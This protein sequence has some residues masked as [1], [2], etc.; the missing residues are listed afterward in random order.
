GNGH[1]LWGEYETAYGQVIQAVVR[2]EPPLFRSSCKSRRKPSKYSLA[3]VL[4]FL[5]RPEAW[6]VQEELPDWALKLLGQQEEKKIPPSTKTN[7]AAQQKR[8]RLMDEGVQELDKW[9]GNLARQGLASAATNPDDWERIAQRMVDC[10]L[11]G[12]GG[13]I[14]RAHEQFTT[15]GWLDDVAGEVGLLYL[16]VRAWQRKTDLAP[17]QK[18][19][20]LQIA[21]WTTRKGDLLHQ[22]GVLDNWLVFGVTTGT[23]EKLTFRRTWLRGE[24]TTRFALILEYVFGNQG[25]EQ[26]WIPGSVLRGELVYYPGQPAIRATFKSLVASRD[27]YEAKPGYTQLA[28]LQTAFAQALRSSPWL[29][30]FPALLTDVAV[31][32]DATPADF[33]LIDQGKYRYPL[34]NDAAAWKALSLSAGMPIS[35]FGEVDGEHFRA[36]AALVDGRVIEL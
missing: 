7:T 34:C 36:V 5:N 1:H 9:L 30:V 28:D 15:D 26:H 31:V 16:F 23:E 8:L 32:Y 19:E 25:F 20:L 22:E 14:R 24:K 33:W 11:G 18:R 4:L 21:G 10:K 17:D 6:Q 12:I 3:L 35:L 29:L 13:R 27:A 2:L